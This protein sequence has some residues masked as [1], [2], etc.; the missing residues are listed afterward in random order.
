MELS[1]I[2]ASWAW[3]KALHFVYTIV[4]PSSSRDRS[5]V[6]YFGGG[7]TLIYAAR[8]LGL[9]FPKNFPKFA[10]EKYQSGRI[11]AGLGYLS[12]QAGECREPLS[13]VSSRE[14]LGE[15]SSSLLRGAGWGL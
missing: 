14:T 1:G 6:K 8:G 7:F 9:Y 12:E 13:P 5:L 11:S 3:L 10:N 2:P 4:I 15:I